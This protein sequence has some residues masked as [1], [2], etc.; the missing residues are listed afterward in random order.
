[1]STLGNGS[2]TRGPSG[3]WSNSMKTRFQTSTQRGHVSEW[4]GT[5]SGPSERWAPR[6]KWI[7]LHGPHG[8]VSAIRQ[9]FLSSPASTSP[10]RAIRSGGR[11]IS[12]RQI[13]HATS[14]SVY[15][16]AARRSPGI[17]SSF[18]RNSQAQWIA[19]RLK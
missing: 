11:P 9:K 12:S 16:V 10:Q 4:S 19:S 18:V 2:G 8:P 14:S 17:P 3:S 7:S 6:S 13:A 1:M 15:V 5:H